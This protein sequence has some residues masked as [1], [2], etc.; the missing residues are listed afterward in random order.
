MSCLEV[1]NLG[2]SILHCWQKSCRL[3]LYEINDASPGLGTAVQATENSNK[4][5]L[6]DL[7]WSKYFTTA[8]SSSNFNLFQSPLFPVTK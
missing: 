7:F 8:C 4:W 5:Y 3:H 6:P 2:G 1:L